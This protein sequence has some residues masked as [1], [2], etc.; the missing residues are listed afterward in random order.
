MIR[1]WWPYITRILSELRVPSSKLLISLMRTRHFQFFNIWAMLWF[2]I[3]SYVA[4]KLSWN[5]FLSFS[6]F[7]RQH[8]IFRRL[9]NQLVK[10]SKMYFYPT[11]LFIVY[12]IWYC[13]YDKYTGKFNIYRDNILYMISIYIEFTGWGFHVGYQYWLYYLDSSHI[14]HHYPP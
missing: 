13:W 1:I 14:L 8:R 5:A 12:D 6:T 3:L 7:L 9:W 4:S 2:I 11:M 10:H